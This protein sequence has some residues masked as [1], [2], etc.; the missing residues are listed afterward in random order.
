M[1]RAMT[2]TLTVEVTVAVT[3]ARYCDTSSLQ[4]L[5]QKVAIAS[6]HTRQIR[7][8]N[9]LKRAMRKEKKREKEREKRR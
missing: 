4:L 1:A 2:A 9:V 5:V 6:P 8:N 7:I 3:Y